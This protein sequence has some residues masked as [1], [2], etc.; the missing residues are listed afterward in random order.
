MKRSQSGSHTGK[1]PSSSTSQS[2]FKSQQYK[3]SYEHTNMI[4]SLNDY[5]ILDNGGGSIKYSR[6]SDALD[7]PKVM[8]NCIARINKQMQVLVGD[9]V[10]D[11]L[12]GKLFI[13]A[14][15]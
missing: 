2:S 13:Y 11:V 4:R 7:R 14:D 12:N 9:Q 3:Q 1:S 8:S 5:I 6:A 10:E 15:M